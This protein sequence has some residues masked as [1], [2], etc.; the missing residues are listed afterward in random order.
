[1]EES[2]HGGNQDSNSQG[3]N[4]A[5][6]VIVGIVLI[7]LVII[8]THVGGVLFTIF[9]A[10]LAW[11][12][13]AEF[14]RM[15][16]FWRPALLLGGIATFSICLAFGLKQEA[17]LEIAAIIL[18]ALFIERLMRTEI[19]L[20]AGSITTTVMGVMYTGWLLG[21]FILLRNMDIETEAA[22]VRGSQ[23]VYLVLVITWTYDTV[24]YMVGTFLGKRKIFSKISPSKTLEGT[25]GGFGASVIASLVSRATFIESIT[26][27]EAVFVGL[28]LAVFAQMGDLVES[29]LKRSA[30]IKDSSHILPGHGGILDRFDSLLFTGPVMYLYAK[31]MML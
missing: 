15:F 18:M 16:A 1:L 11:V 25:V 24:A 22:T 12:A 14:C 28:L 26:I 4:L 3:R 21:Y 17:S 6:R 8:I 31:L 23:L 29:V 7:P 20:F 13:Y 9:V 30:G 19:R 5:K 27:S 10:S 2:P